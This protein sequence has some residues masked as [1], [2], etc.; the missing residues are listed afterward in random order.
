MGLIPDQ[1]AAIGTHRRYQ[2]VEIPMRP[3]LTDK[4]NPRKVIRAG[5]RVVLEAAATVCPAKWHVD[6]V[7]SGLL[8]SAGT[9]SYQRRI[10]EGEDSEILVTFVAF[11]D[12]DLNTIMS[13]QWFVRLYAVS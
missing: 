5:E 9:C 8:E 11:E 13:G 7:T 10:A 2:Y 3:V 6:V 4:G 1:G 12:L